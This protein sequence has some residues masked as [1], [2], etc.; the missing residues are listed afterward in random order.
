MNLN[1][2]ITIITRERFGN[3]MEIMS[4]CIFQGE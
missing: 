4:A 3:T 1:G 2:R